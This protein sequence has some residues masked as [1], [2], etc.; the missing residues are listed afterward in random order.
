MTLYQSGRGECPISSNFKLTADTLYGQKYIPQSLCLVNLIVLL[1]V[2]SICI[3]FGATN[4]C[5][6]NKVVM[7]F[8]TC[9]VRIKWLIYS[10]NLFRISLSNIGIIFI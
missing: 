4:N 9:C 1:Y 6:L 8:A 7:R 3:V 5:L 2:Y 10:I